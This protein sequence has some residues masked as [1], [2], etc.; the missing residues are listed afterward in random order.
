MLG[1]E[2]EAVLNVDEVGRLEGTKLGEIVSEIIVAVC[3][4]GDNEVSPVLV[5]GPD[6]PEFICVAALLVSRTEVFD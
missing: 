1:F 6:E 5:V 3:V 4:V 2:R